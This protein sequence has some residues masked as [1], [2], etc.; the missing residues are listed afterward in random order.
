M[1]E[2][3]DVIFYQSISGGSHIEVRLEDETVWLSQGQMQE[4]FRQTKQR[5]SLH[6]NNNFNEREL[7][8]E[9]TVRE[10]LTVQKERR[11]G[12]CT[13]RTVRKDRG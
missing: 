1:K 10:F 9:S 3:G 6:I 2:K 4:L 11:T 5:T 7:V 13:G 12:Y 8:R